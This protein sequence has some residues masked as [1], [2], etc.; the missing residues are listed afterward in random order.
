M[1]ETNEGKSAPVGGRGKRKAVIGTV[2]S[3]KM[4]KTI[5]V[6]VENRSPHPMFGKVVKKITK[7]RAHD[8]KE[9]ASEGDQVE[10]VETRPLSKTKRWR[11]LRVVSKASV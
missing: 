9:E 7:Y 5:T 6:R 8:E 3:D 1:A 10:I 4:D 11:L 2:L